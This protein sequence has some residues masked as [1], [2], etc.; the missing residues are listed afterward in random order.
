M[1][2]VLNAI[3]ENN[4]RTA[5]VEI[6][7]FFK[8][9]AE[10]F[11]E[12]EIKENVK[13]KTIYSDE[14]IDFLD[15]FIKDLKVDDEDKFT[16]TI[17]IGSYIGQYAISKL[18]GNWCFDVLSCDSPLDFFIRCNSNFSFRPFLSVATKIQYGKK[19]TFKSEIEI[20]KKRIKE[21]NKADSLTINYFLK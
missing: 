5:M 8:K 13:D 6:S 20:L 4:V 7:D 12:K 19:E 18:K 11:F 10:L 16:C 1:K 17:V 2:K 9:N 14:S 3:D 21:F 15:K